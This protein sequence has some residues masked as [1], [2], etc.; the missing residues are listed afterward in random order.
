MF[1]KL[2]CMD[3]EGTLLQKTHRLDDGRVAPSTWTLLAEYLGSD[4]LREEQATKERWL[5]K[6]YKN[7]IEWMEDTIMIHKRFGLTYE[8][9]ERVI[10]SV[11]E[12]P[13]AEDAIRSFHSRGAITAIVS[14]GFKALADKV[15]VRFKIR[16]ALSA[17]EY[18]FDP[19]TGVLEHWNLLPSDYEG[20]RNFIR[21]LR[22]EY[23]L[24]KR[25]CVFIG[26]GQNDVLAAKE[27]GLSIGFNPQPEFRRVCTYAIDQEPHG[28]DFGEVVGCIERLYKA[29]LRFRNC[30][31][32]G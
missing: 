23:R 27:V 22:R 2:I 6:G 31:A 3:L 24:A 26:D 21:L 16:H 8:V 7:Y 17:C 14:G 9:F 11:P 29:R 15:Q 18:F 10:D 30:R 13:G 28:E 19:R 4:A 1:P 12:M 5:N 20:K 32:L 25:E